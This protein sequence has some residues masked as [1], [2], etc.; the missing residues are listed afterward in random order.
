MPHDRL[1]KGFEF[2]PACAKTLRCEGREVA[3]S[4]PIRHR[5]H[6]EPLNPALPRVESL[7]EASDPSAERI[8]ARMLHG[9]CPKTHRCSLARR[10]SAGR[11]LLL[12][13]GAQV[14]Q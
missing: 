10:R 9:P 11:G 2:L 7:R 6:R 12:R 5:K 8:N 13:F 1:T 3:P 14:E 4:G